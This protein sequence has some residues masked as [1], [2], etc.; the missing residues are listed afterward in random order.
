MSSVE[1]ST[2]FGVKGRVAVITGGSSGIGFMIAKGFVTN[3]A[4]VYI[5]ALPTDPIA[6]KV[7]E[8]NSLGKNAGGSAEAIP[9]N[10]MSKESISTLASEISQREK[11][12]DI[13]ISN[14]G[15]RR[16]P[17]QSCNVLTASLQDLQASMWSSNYSDWE[18]TFRINTTAH[19]FLSVALFP[20]LAAAAERTLPDGSKG[21]DEGR[22][23]IVVTSSCASLHNCTNVDLTSYATSKAGTDHLV[24]LLASKFQRCLAGAYVNGVSLCV[25]GGRILL[26]NGQE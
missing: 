23:V 5:C 8:L 6:E 16:D 3:G 7:A 13:L 21:R 10:L 4:K 12:I 1:V 19:Y 14:A 18:D 9:C 17:P 24:R 15:I 11:Y 2:L 25:D 22:G 20:L 26:A